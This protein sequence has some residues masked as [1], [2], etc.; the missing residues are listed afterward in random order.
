[1]YFT[2]ILRSLGFSTADSN[3]LSIPPNVFFIVTVCFFAPILMMG[4]PWLT[5]LYGQGFIAALVAEKTEQRAYFMSFAQVWMM[6][7][8]VGV[9]TLPDGAGR[10]TVYALCK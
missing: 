2:L 8:F 9:A 3:L 7:C 10:W 1:M 6:V 5:I 4:H